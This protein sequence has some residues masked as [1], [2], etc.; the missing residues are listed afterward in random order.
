MLQ[1][2]APVQNT[3][4]AKAIR[5][6]RFPPRPAGR[7]PGRGRAAAAAMPSRLAQNG[8]VGTDMGIKTS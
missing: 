4:T 1:H 3:G 2:D 6:C 7:P 5:G 8:P